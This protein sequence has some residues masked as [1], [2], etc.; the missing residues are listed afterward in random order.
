MSRPTSHLSLDVNCEVLQAPIPPS[1][2]S[3]SGTSRNSAQSFAALTGALQEVQI[4]N[5]ILS[6]R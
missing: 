6:C 1:N 2:A 5:S 3:M 4:V